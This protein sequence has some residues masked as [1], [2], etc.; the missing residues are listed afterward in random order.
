MITQPN[1]IHTSWVELVF[2]VK[3]N[4]VGSYLKPNQ[5]QPAHSNAVACQRN[6]ACELK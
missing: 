6:S 1:L 5:A 3:M 4:W 2:K